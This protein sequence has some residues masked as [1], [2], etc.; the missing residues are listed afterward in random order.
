MKIIILLIFSILISSDQVPAPDQSHPILLKNGVLHTVSNG[1]VHGPD[2]LFDNGE[3]IAIGHHIEISKETQ[4]ID[5]SG[6]HIY[7]L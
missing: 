2:L 5:V 3:I 1:T 4:I 6:K 7:T